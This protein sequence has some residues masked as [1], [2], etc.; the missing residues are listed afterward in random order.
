MSVI[1]HL[2]RL[3]MQEVARG[4]RP[5]RVMLT[6]SDFELVKIEVAAS[7]YRSEVP[8]TRVLGMEI[9][10]GPRTEIPK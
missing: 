7:G 4:L 1:T 5:T 10:I 3:Q 8:V 2:K 9:E 6:K